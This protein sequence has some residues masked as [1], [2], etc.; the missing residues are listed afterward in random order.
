MAWTV[1]FP[2]LSVFRSAF[3]LVEES[4]AWLS[5]QYCGHSAHLEKNN[6]LHG[7]SA[8]TA[9]DEGDILI[10]HLLFKS[11]FY[12][13]VSSL[14]ASHSHFIAECCPNR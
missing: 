13:Q 8:A 3:G 10:P 2:I 14:P 6:G 9:D 5:G 11:F 12:F 7:G 1:A 4:L